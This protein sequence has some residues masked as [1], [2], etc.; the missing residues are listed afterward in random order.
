VNNLKETGGEGFDHFDFWKRSLYTGTAAKLLTQRLG[1]VQQEEAFLGGLLQDVGMMALHETLQDEYT[2]VLQQVGRRHHELSG[3]ETQTLQLTHAE[4]GRVLAES[5]GLPPLLSACIGHHEAPEQAEASVRPVVRCVA[6]GNDV[7]E[8]FMNEE[9]GVDAINDYYDHAEAWCNL[10]PAEAEPL[11]K[12]IHKSVIELRGLFDL[13]VGDL[14]NPD[15]ILTKANEALMQMSL[16]SHRL[17]SELQQ[18][19]RQLQMMAETDSLTG[20]MNR[21]RFNEVL[22]AA[23][24]EATAQRPLSLLFLDADHFKAINDSYGH[25]AGD[26]VLVELAR[27]LSE[28]SNED[29]AV[30]RYGGEEF[31]IVMPRT[32]RRAASIRAEQLRQMIAAADIDCGEGTCLQVTASIGVATHDGGFFKAVDQ[33]IKAADQGVYAAKASG[34]NCVR[35]FTP[36]PK[37]AA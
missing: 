3:A 33:L 9:A 25:P 1:M 37:V 14:R 18:R 19:N 7:A 27:L 30:A 11:L 8:V 20:V 4:V 13:P 32:D 24:A 22:A 15:V 2:P 12:R 36:R 29:A 28:Q 5:W 35:I 26:R 23:F 21:G 10:S 31:A 16:Q 6:L 17:S 34:R